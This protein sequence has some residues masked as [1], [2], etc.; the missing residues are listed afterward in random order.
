MEA[1]LQAARPIM[2][3]LSNLKAAQAETYYQA[4]DY[5]T[6]EASGAAEFTPQWFGRGATALGLSGDVSGDDFKSLLHGYGLDGQALF[7]RQV[8]VEKRR[9]A[10]DYTFSAPKSVSVAAL[11]QQDER[12]LQAHHQAVKTALSVLE[13]RYVEA[14]ITI[15]PGDRRRVNTGNIASALFPHQTSRELDPQLHTH[16]VTINATQAPDGRWFSFSNESVIRQQ[17]LLGEV[18]QTGLTQEPFQQWDALI[19]Q[20]GRLK[21]FHV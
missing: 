4:D 2:L 5:Y 7:Q 19:A 18:Y 15:A 16:C 21:A 8:D 12:V 13:E 9:G 10:T 11:V 1:V 6:N 20:L 3:S 14:R 17:K